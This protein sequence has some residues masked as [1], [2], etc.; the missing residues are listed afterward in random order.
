M[1]ESLILYTHGL[2]L[3]CYA[4]GFVEGNSMVRTEFLRFWA[5]FATLMTVCMFVVSVDAQTKPVEAK[6]PVADILKHPEARQAF[7][8]SLPT[9]T[10]DG[11]LPQIYYLMEGDLLLTE[12][13][14]LGNLRSYGDSSTT[15][16][17]SGELK[18]ML[19][20]NSVAI[21]GKSDRVLTYAVARSSFSSPAAYQAVVNNMMAATKA[22]M[23]ACK[24]CGVRFEHR[25]DQDGAPNLQ[26]VRFIV[27][28]KPDETRFIA[29]A[30]FPN[31][32]VAR[33]YLFIAPSYFENQFDG[34]GVLRHELG[35]VLGYRHEHI[36][37][38]PGCGIEDSSWKAVTVYDPK[39]V[40]H[41]YCGNGGTFDM[42]LTEKD[43][44]GHADTYK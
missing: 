26:Q 23:D 10:I 15:P 41:Y 25:A 36:G 11:E 39:S 20:G 18:V 6:L 3:H 27:R 17:Y 40:M 31:D 28:Y 35:H 4:R 32:P 5:G 22:W 44:E 14:V 21:W 13:Q 19:Q 42:Q 24:T 12:E 37:G 16:K 33:R 9:V 38:V 34:V 7:L 2:V 30:F 8:K 43:K 1:T 29:A